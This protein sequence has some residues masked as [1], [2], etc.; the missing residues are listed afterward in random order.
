[1]DKSY[2]FRKSVQWF[3]LK[4]EEWVWSIV[5]W[6]ENKQ[7]LSIENSERWVEVEQLA[8]NKK[9]ILSIIQKLNE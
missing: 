4:L 5:Y 7:S 9:G 3:Y 8:E 6:E 1:M 2:I